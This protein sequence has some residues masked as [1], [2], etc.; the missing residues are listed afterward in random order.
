MSVMPVS[1]GLTMKVLKI[2]T[3]GNPACDPVSEGII[4]PADMAAVIENWIVGVG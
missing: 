3:K 2:I 4:N 1:R